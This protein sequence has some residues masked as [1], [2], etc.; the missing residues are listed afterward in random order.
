MEQF[1]KND[2]IFAERPSPYSETPTDPAGNAADQ[3]RE[4][5]PEQQEQPEQ[6]AQQ[7]QQGQPEQPWQQGWQEQPAQFSQE[8]TA[9]RDDRPLNTDGGIFGERSFSGVMRDPAASSEAYPQGAHPSGAYPQGTYPPPYTG[10]PVQADAQYGN[11]YG[12]N[13]Y[14]APNNY[15]GYSGYDPYRQPE[16]NYRQ[17][18]PQYGAYQ[19][20]YASAQFIPQPVAP[21]IPPVS[22]VPAAEIKKTSKGWIIAMIIAAVLALSAV[23]ILLAMNHSGKDTPASDAINSLFENSS[24]EKNNS[25][26]GTGVIVNISVAPKP[27]EGDEYYQNKETGLLT[28]AGAAKQ[29]LP[30]IVNLYGYT[31]TVLSP[32]NEA[33]GV[34]ISEDGYIVTNAHVLDEIKRVKAKLNDGS[35]YEAEIIGIDTKT[36]L[37][38]LKID[39]DNITPAVIGASDDLDPGEQVVAIGNAGGF[40]DT[41][42]VGCVSH[43][44]RVIDS[45]TGYPVHCVQTDAVL[46]FGN[47][48]GALVNLYGQVVGIVTSKYSQVGDER[49]GFAI[50]TEDAVPVVEDII[51]KGYV[52]GRPR[53]GVMYQLITA[54][55]ASRLEVKPGMMISE[56]SDDCDIANTELQTDDIITELD[57]IQILITDDIQNFQQ[58]HKPGDTVT[59]KVYRKSITGEETEFEITF[60]LEENDG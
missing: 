4:A 11:I 13:Q 19:P 26:E 34:I 60:K 12:R 30:S 5:Q 40:N 41:V 9:Y 54:E 10:E 16:P 31:N 8:N 20:N 42:T 57:G 39:A 1:E 25:S 21:D 50:K 56:I 49:V 58:M 59:A 52:T 17:A 22:D 18:P 14:N 27:V 46:N 35:E 47:S 32:Y 51:E 48:G 53:V 29:V 24:S 6:S 28:P 45:Y 55:M 3:D 36:D 38:V 37:A 33:S 7:E 15:G 44:D 43:T 23:M 2:D